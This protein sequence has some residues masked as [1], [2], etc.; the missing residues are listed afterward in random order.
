MVMRWLLNEHKH[1]DT[2]PPLSPCSPAVVFLDQQGG[3]IG[4]R[5]K[6]VVYRE[7]TNNKFTTQVE[8]TADM[9]HLG[10]M[11]KMRGQHLQIID[12]ITQLI[13]LSRSNDS[14]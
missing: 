11:G 7:F 14:R 1:S 2:I 10:I 3:F 6:K 13:P 8:R 4:S 12:L 5:Y 9:E